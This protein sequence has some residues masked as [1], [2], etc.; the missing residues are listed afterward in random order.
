[1]KCGMFERVIAPCFE[2]EGKIEDHGLI[3]P[4]TVTNCAS[5]LYRKRN[6]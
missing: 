2:N 1:M 4:I 3:I 5:L 6:L